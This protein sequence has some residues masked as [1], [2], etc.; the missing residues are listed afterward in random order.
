MFGSDQD[1]PL[2]VQFKEQGQSPYKQ[3][4]PEAAAFQNQG[5][6]VAEGQRAMRVQ[7][8]IFLGWT[9]TEA[10]YFLT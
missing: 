5:Q 10:A 4:L 9:S 6:R 7:S 1:D 8:D 3:Y 2:F